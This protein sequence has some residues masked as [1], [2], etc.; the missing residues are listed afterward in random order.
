MTGQR[1]PESL[2]VAAGQHHGG[3]EADDG[4][5]AGDLEDLADDRLAH[6]GLQVVQ[7][8][9]VV[10]GEAGAVIAVVDVARLAAALV[11]ALEDDRGIGGVPVVILELDDHAVIGR[12]VLTAEGVGLEGWVGRGDEALRVF[13]HPAR[14]DA[15]VVG[16]HV[17]RQADAAGSGA[18]AQVPPG[19]VATQLISDA[20]VG[21]RVGRGH[22]IGVAAHLLDA[23]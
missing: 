16:H 20:V 15:H 19:I 5:A 21:D 11:D 8:R 10:P 17:G 6:V 4:E 1:I 23:P 2:D 13:D 12:E 3:V 18:L 7:L 9:R 14:I 22:G